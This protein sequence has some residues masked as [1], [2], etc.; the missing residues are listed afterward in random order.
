MKP[1]ER[2]EN[3]REMADDPAIRSGVIKA[4]ADPDIRALLR[5]LITRS[6]LYGEAKHTDPT[7]LALAMG[8]QNAGRDLVGLLLAVSPGG[9]ALMLQEDDSAHAEAALLRGQAPS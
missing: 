6:G 7:S 9:Y 2:I 8:W 3:L 5:V 4:V 1:I